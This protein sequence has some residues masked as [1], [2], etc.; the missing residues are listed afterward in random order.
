MLMDQ[1]YE[2]GKDR[3]RPRRSRCLAT[4]NR[5]GFAF[6]SE[7]EVRHGQRPCLRH[8]NTRVPQQPHDDAVMVRA[9][10]AEQRTVLVVRRKSFGRWG[11]GGAQIVRTGLRR[12][13]PS[14]PTRSSACSRYAKKTRSAPI[15]PRMVAGRGR[16]L[17]RPWNPTSHVVKKSSR[18]AG[19]RSPT[20]R[21]PSQS[22][23]PRSEYKY[24]RRVE[25]ARPRRRRCASKLSR[26]LSADTRSSKLSMP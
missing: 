21:G 6:R 7:V 10:R 13:E 9:V 3:D 22:Q 11:H 26:S 17:W 15:I 25:S 24:W 2:L 23:K 19:V 20:P 18:S 14:T 16:W 4:A 12:R 1:G 8:A 5:Q